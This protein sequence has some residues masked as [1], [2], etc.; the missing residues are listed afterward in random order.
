[1]FYQINHS[2]ISVIWKNSKLSLF[3]NVKINSGFAHEG[4]LKLKKKTIS[5]LQ[6][7][8]TDMTL[9]GTIM[10][11]YLHRIDSP[12]LVNKKET[13]LHFVSC[14]CVCV[15]VCVCVY[16]CHM[17]LHTCVHTFNLA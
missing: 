11:S 14:E 7:L 8:D 4:T 6:N 2:S 16:I 10:I 17:A 9:F 15:C 3:T 1:M 13:I 5:L 12:F